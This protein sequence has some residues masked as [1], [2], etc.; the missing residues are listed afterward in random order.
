MGISNRWI[1]TINTDG[2]VTLLQPAFTNIQRGRRSASFRF[3]GA[4]A[5]GAVSAS[6]G[7]TANFL[8]ADGSWVVPPGGGGGTTPTV[9]QQRT[10]NATTTSFTLAAGDI[11]GGYVEHALEFTGNNVSSTNATLPTVA[12][13]VASFSPVVGQTYKL[14]ITNSGSSNWTVVTNTGWTLNGVMIVNPDTF[15]DYYV[16]FTSLV[17]ATLQSV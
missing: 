17:A 11:S 15:M 8:R 16:T 1:T 13:L 3:S 10:T 14:R 7:G 5:A 2:S 12:N 4:A 9:L 6:G